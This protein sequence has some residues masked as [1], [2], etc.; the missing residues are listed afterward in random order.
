M[1]PDGQIRPIVYVERSEEKDVRKTHPCHV[2]SRPASPELA[3]RRA[4]DEARCE[5]QNAKDEEVSIVRPADDR[6]DCHR[7]EDDRETPTI[8]RSSRRMSANALRTE[9]GDCTR[10]DADEAGRDVYANSGEEDWRGRR[11]RN[12]QN[13]DALVGQR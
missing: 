6:E 9:H 7:Y 1:P 4:P 13:H 12:P 11:D 5:R 2:N 8:D 10:D 3:S